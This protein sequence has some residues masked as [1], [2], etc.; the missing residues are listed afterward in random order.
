MSSEVIEDEI[1][2]LKQ[3]VENLERQ[4]STPQ[5][6]GWEA[7]AGKAKDDDLLEE[8]MRLGAQWRAQANANGN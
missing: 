3:R 7:I 4:T 1:A 6:G 8:A 5:R 2:A